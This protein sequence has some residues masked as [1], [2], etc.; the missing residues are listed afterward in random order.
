MPELCHSLGTALPSLWQ[1]YAMPM[2]Q[3]CQNDGKIWQKLQSIEHTQ[4]VSEESLSSALS[5]LPK[6]LSE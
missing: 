2:A 4:G 5:P 3:L 6:L 1:D